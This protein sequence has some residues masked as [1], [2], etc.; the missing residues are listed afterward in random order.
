[1]ERPLIF[2]RI[3]TTILLC[4]LLCVQKVGGC[5]VSSGDTRHILA[6][7]Y[8]RSE[9]KCIEQSL[10]HRAQS[11]IDL[12]LYYDPHVLGDVLDITRD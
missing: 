6:A 3:V 2:F 5:T 1:M 9:Y 7:C 10:P 8:P 4:K 12:L 11:M